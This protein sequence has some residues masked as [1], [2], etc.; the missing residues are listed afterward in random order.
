MRSYY[1]RKVSEDE[2]FPEPPSE[3]DDPYEGRI[4]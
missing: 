1:K 4:V 2:T 3:F